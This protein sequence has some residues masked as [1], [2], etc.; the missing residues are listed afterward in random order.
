MTACAPGYYC[1]AGTTTKLDCPDGA[2]CPAGSAIYIECPVGT[3]G[4]G[5]ANPATEADG[6][7]ECDANKFC[8]ERGMTSGLQ[9]SC[10]NGF[11]CGP[12]T[13]SADPTKATKGAMAAAPHPDQAGSL[14]PEG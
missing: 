2:Y 13:P 9:Q 10:G 12:G 4:T 6:C 14:C 7:Q 3:Y 5:N 11:V 1:P 8:G